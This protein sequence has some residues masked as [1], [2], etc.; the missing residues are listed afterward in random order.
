MGTFRVKE[1]AEARG[2]SQEDLAFKSR[3][4]MR[5]VQRLWQDKIEKPYAETLMRLA[6]A[7]EVPVRELYTEDGLKSAL[8]DIRMPSHAAGELI[9]A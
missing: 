6:D 5:T 1:L 9:P 4:K 3:V 7:L 8:E 2:M